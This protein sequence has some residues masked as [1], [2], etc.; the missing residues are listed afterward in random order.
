MI[1]DVG[2]WFIVV[3]TS[4]AAEAAMRAW[5][6]RTSLAAERT[7]LLAARQKHQ[8]N[9]AQLAP[10][11]FRSAEHTV[12]RTVALGLINLRTVA[13]LNIYSGT[14]RG[15]SREFVALSVCLSLGSLVD[16]PSNATG[17]RPHPCTAASASER[18]RPFRPTRLVYVG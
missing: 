5:I 14:R 9:T 6:D 15:E 10:Y 7:E 17:Q 12:S 11:I 13:Q 1:P 2:H 16:S 8:T 3:D 4:P 18:G